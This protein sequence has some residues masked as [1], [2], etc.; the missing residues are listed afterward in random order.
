MIPRHEDMYMST[1]SI[2]RRPV[3]NQLAAALGYR[4]ATFFYTHTCS[5][6]TQREMRILKT[7]I[8]SEEAVD[9]C[10]K[11]FGKDPKFASLHERSLAREKLISASCSI[12]VRSWS[13]VSRLWM[14]YITKSPEKPIGFFLW[15]WIRNELQ[16][17]KG[18]LAHIHSILWHAD[19][20]GSPEST[21]K[22]LRMIRAS[23][24]G[25][26]TPEELEQYKADGILSSEQHLLEILELLEQFLT[27]KHGPRCLILRKQ[28]RSFRRAKISVGRN[29]KMMSAGA[30]DVDMTKKMN[31]YR[32]KVTDNYSIS[33]NPTRD[34]WINIR[35]E[36]SKGASEILQQI[37]L[38]T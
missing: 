14:A 30:E 33:P 31:L 38:I 1:E 35:A 10:L 32:C 15:D 37:G 29:T 11:H 20:D 2:D 19:D 4:M 16:D 12:A 3:V 26:V 24:S 36:H 23:I 21:R 25:M 8:D 6:M 27:H 28:N 7:W 22:L 13:I 18:N 34:Q 9:E 5:M 17:K